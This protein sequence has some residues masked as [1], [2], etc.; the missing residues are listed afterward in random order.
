MLISGKFLVGRLAFPLT[1]AMGVTWLLLASGQ[2]SLTAAPFQP[3]RFSP[4]HQDGKCWAETR[5]S[6]PDP[7]LLR[8]PVNCEMMEEQEFMS[9]RP[10][11]T[12]VAL[13]LE[14]ISQP[15]ILRLS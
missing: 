3:G 4:G 13:L 7:S 14:E 15:H 6:L 11:S 12:P 10:L 1:S 2:V 8:A 5:R 9:S